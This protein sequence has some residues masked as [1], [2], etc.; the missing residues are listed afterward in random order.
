MPGN[1]GGVRSGVSRLPH[2]PG[3]LVSVTDG[4]TSGGLLWEGLTGLHGGD[5]GGPSVPHHLQQGGGCSDL[6]LGRGDS[7]EC[8]NAGW[9][10]TG[11]QTPK[12]PLLR[13]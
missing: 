9:V 10:H 1:Y 7:R 11:G 13:R 6:V 5:T 4:R 3:I 8:R 2:P 12:R